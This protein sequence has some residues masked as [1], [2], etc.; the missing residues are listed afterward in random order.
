M[1]KSGLVAVALAALFGIS[2]A[3]SA[4]EA[5]RTETVKSLESDKLADGIATLEVM[6][7]RD[8][9]NDEARFGVGM[10]RFI[11]AIEHL[12]QG[13]YK[14]GLQPPRSM[15]MPI[16]RLPVP[17]NP[18]PEPVDYEKFRAILLAFVADLS[19]AESTLAGIGTSDVKIPVNLVTIRYDADGDGTVGADETM[20]AALARFLEVDVA[21]I[22]AQPM[23]VAF[24]HADAFWL[25]GYC[26]VLMALSEF[27]LA[28]DWHESFD[29]SFHVFFP[30]AHS[31]FQM[32]LAPPS[33][34]FIFS[35][36]GAIA[37][38]ISFLHIRWPVSE[39]ARMAAVREHLK[40]MIAL[41]RQDFSAV[42]AE[43]DDDHEWIPNAHQTGAAGSPVNAEQ[44]AAWEKVLD[45]F[46][47][48]LDGRKLMPHWRMK[49]GI[50]LR[51]VF[52]DPRPFDFVLWIT[53]PA[54]LPYVEDGPVLTSEEWRGIIRAFE[55]SFGSYAIWF[56]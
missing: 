7:A 25:R 5:A 16:V 54:A 36:E 52:E 50:N 49:Q 47:A 2:V 15:M 9:G 56:N 33:D 19:A 14:Y 35:S 48:L 21:E 22:A 30:R 27:L 6:V 11:Q 42:V 53:G 39:P 51:K 13:L 41:S 4:D 55:G 37:D 8:S 20:T 46:D 28:H 1:C 45:E 31:P 44:I 10:V 3:A 29:A 23:V 38:L 18:N 32:A 12:S 40:S 26:N 34:G 24:D 43:T 17:E